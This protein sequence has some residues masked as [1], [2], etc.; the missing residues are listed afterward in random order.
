MKVNIL[1]NAYENMLM[2]LIYLNKFNISK[3]NSNFI[4]DCTFTKQHKIYS[5]INNKK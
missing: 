3:Y 2:S 4:R 5:K 1:E